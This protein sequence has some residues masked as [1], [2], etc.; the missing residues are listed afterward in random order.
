MSSC[1]DNVY[2]ALKGAIEGSTDSGLRTA[3]AAALG[4]AKIDAQK[5]A[6]LRKMLSRVAGSSSEG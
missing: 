3:I 2:A 1:P 6:E 5:K 4:M